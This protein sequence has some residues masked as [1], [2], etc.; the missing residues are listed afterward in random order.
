MILQELT[1]LYDRLEADP[2]T[3][4][5]P[6]GSIVQGVAFAVVLDTE[7]RLVQFEDLRVTEGKKVR[8]YPMT[9]PGNSKK[10]GSGINS[11]LQGWDRTDYLLGYLD[12]S[13]FSEADQKKKRK[14]MGLCHADYKAKMLAR[15]AEVNHPTYS[16]FCR[17]LEA[18]DPASAESHPL[19]KEVTGQVGVVR[20]VGQ[21][22]YLHEIPA[23][24]EVAEPDG[25]GQEGM[26][27]VTGERDRI[28]RTHDIK[29]KGFKDQGA[30]VSFNLGA[31]ESYGQ[32]QAFNAPV[33]E[34]A[35]FKYA[36]AL[37]YLIREPEH[38]V[39]VGDITLVF[40][41]DAPTMADALFGYALSSNATDTDT[42]NRLHAALLSM[43][44]GTVRAG[45]DNLLD[46]KTG[47]CVLGLTPNVA[48]LSVRFWFRSTV[49]DMFRRVVR[50]QEE[51]EIVR[52]AKDRDILPVW[53]LL[54]Q[55]ARESKEIPPVLGVALL[56]SILGGTPYPLAFMAAV[57]RRIRA[58]RVVN[59]PRAAILKAVLTRNFKKEELTMLNPERTEVGYQ[60]GRLFA[61]LERAQE[62]ALP[63]LN[64]TIKDRYFGAASATP[65]SVF[66]RLIR[67]S[68]HHLGKLDGGKKVV[69]EKRIQ[70]IFGRVNDFPA[71]LDLPGQGLFAIGYYHQRQDFF[72]PK[73][74]KD[75]DAV[76]EVEVEAEAVEE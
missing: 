46:E 10:T 44:R 52:S 54:A 28:A 61:A 26:C 45:D 24:Q 23:M 25:D 50:H 37:N 3:D 51:L 56:R 72:T 76:T 53:L 31:F 7:G 68:Q 62:D 16:A 58:D 27:L 38:K 32:S 71:Q 15:E 49:G 29:I 75:A 12:L 35:A 5:A 21:E 19:L 11:S 22:E 4:V 43:K 73:K 63:G 1:R 67:M 60:L 6:V 13:T 65:G 30:L 41:A 70:E 69:A 9:L 33:G 2:D 47:F 18:W 59:H 57:L 74:D 55:T 17:F 66:P 14:R 36:T 64:A 48:R 42:E 8:L 39:F 40:W 34:T 20:I